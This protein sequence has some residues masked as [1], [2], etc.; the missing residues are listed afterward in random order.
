MYL[1]PMQIMTNSGCLLCQPPLCDEEFVRS[2]L[3]RDRR[4]WRDNAVCGDG[5]DDFVERE[6]GRKVYW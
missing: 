2:L 4:E 6:S 1:L 3:Q 5:S